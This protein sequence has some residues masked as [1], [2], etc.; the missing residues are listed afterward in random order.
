MSEIFAGFL[1][2]L[3]HLFIYLFMY[4]LFYL[5]IFRSCCQIHKTFLEKNES[6]IFF[7]FLNLDIIMH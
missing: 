3:H 7:L 2:F 5:F 4:L 1:P 6:A